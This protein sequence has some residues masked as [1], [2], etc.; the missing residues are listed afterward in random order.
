MTHK[1]LKIDFKT[2]LETQLKKLGI[3]N[4]LTLSE[5]T[6]EIKHGKTIKNVEDGKEMLNVSPKDAKDKFAKEGRR[7]LCIHE[8]LALLRANKNLLKDHYVDLVGSR[9]GAERSPS[10]CLSVDG[11][12]LHSYWGGNA[13]PYWGAASCLGVSESLG[14]SS[15]ELLEIKVKVG[16][17][18]INLIPE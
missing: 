4:Y 18:I 13:V 3:K 12:S 1:S 17:R 11:P 5:L 8:G 6:C 15:L 14:I 10:L 9:C 16:E 7:G 2:P